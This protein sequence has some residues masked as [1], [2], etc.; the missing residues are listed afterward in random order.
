M[1]ITLQE[2]LDK[3]RELQGSATD[4]YYQVPETDEN[5]NARSYVDKL[6]YEID[7]LTIEVEKINKEGYTI[8]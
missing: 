8:S 4:A 3:L 1:K 5:E 7:M 2:I 6:R